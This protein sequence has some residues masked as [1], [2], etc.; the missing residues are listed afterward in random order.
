MGPYLALAGLV[1]LGGVAKLARP[2]ETAKAIAKVGVVAPVATVRALAAAEVVVGIGAAVE[3]RGLW[4]WA[5]AAS[6]VGFTALVLAALVL[7]LP[8]A[9]C[10]CFGEPDTPPTLSH[11]CLTAAASAMAGM[12]AAG[13]G[14]PGLFG[15]GGVTLD[16][17]LA[18]VAWG[19]ASISTCY[20]G[21]LG[22]SGLGRLKVSLARG[23]GK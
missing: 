22:L 19:L 10:G 14:S 3:P 11:V 1:V 5:L 23:E 16:S 8:L 4:A 20:L 18:K 12:V 21:Y 9:T 6:Y 15:M 2:S 7:Q 17:W 13:G